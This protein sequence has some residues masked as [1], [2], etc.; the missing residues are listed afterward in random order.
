M[1][2]GNEMIN[3]S[4]M[5][6]PRELFP[7]QSH[8]FDL[9]AYRLHFIDEGCGPVIL[10][11]HSCPLWSFEYRDFILDL[12]K[13]YRVIAIDQLGFGLSDKPEDADFRLEAHADHLDRFCS[14]LELENIIL[15]MHGR[16]ATIG[17][18][19]AVRHPDNIC[20]IITLNAMAFSG[21]SLPMRLQL[22]RIKWFGARLIM[23]LGV[24]LYDIKK[25]NPPVRDG[26]LYP[27]PDEKSKNAIFHFI[28]DFPCVPEDDSSQTMFEVESTIWMLKNKPACIIWAAK[29]WLYNDR[30]RI[31]WGQYFPHA[32]MTVLGSAGRCATEDAPGEILK[33][34]HTFLRQ[35]NL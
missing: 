8:F 13:K 5:R 33:A 2:S 34:I 14:E 23:N 3:D 25:L 11:L 18:S 35:N 10:M 17:M 4:G 32:S 16:G 21:F 29:D 1:M 24:F 28:E 7:F 15:L 20:A 27:F 30:N 9:G 31:R 6:F 22:C 12:R 19:L 26:Y